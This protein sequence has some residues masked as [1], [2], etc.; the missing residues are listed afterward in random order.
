MSRNSL[1]KGTLI[2]TIAFIVAR[3][4]GV[5]QRVPLQHIMGNDGMN[6][7]SISFNLYNMLLTV[8]TL[9][10][11]TALAKQISEYTA[12]GK[13]SEAYQTYKASRNFAI[14]AGLVVTAFLY[15]FGPYYANSIAMAP[16]A[17][18][19]IQALAPAMM[20]FPLIAVMRG[21]FQGMQQ[22]MPTGISLIYEQIFRVSA[23]VILPL[24]LLGLNFSKEVAVAGASFGAVTG[25]IAAIAVMIYYYKKNRPIQVK[26]I[27]GQKSSSQLSVLTIYKKLFRLSIPITVASLTVTLLYFIDSSTGLR[28]LT[29]V[30]EQLFFN[31]NS[32]QASVAGKEMK[33]PVPVYSLGENTMVPLIPV[34]EALGGSVQWDES[35]QTA[36]YARNNQTI[37]LALNQDISVGNI[38]LKAPMEKKEQTLMVPASF[39]TYQLSGYRAAMEDMGILNGSAQSLAGLPI[40]L[41]VALSSSILPIVSAAYSRND[42]KEVQRMSSL[43]L[44][45]ALLTGV[46]AALFLTVGAL[47]VNGLLFKNSP[48]IIM[49]ASYII[50]FLCFGTIFQILMMIS[51][52]ILQGMGK[53]NHPMLFVLIGVIVKWIGNFVFTPFMGIYGIILSTSLCFLVIT[54][55]NIRAIN[56][57]TRLQVMGSKWKGL[58]GGSL[59][60]SLTGLGVVLLGMKV[61]P[62]V[63]IYDFLFYGL[64][65]I[66]LGVVSI[67]A[68]VLTLFWLKGMDANE[69]QYMPGIAKKAYNTLA[70]LHIVPRNVARELDVK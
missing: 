13:Y 21:Y 59:S 52:S 7:Y 40:I 24:V 9:G 58:I 68:Y 34:A 51:M 20:F 11:P 37:G 15:A 31:L 12:V 5:I 6:L 16:Q 29:P 44:R 18:L 2:L 42:E 4:L 36:I 55:L 33:L 26:Q 22:M 32:T 27:K 14:I 3:M 25:T 53:T 57:V 64:E 65:T 43:S 46:P 28:L 1:V 47:P 19:A 61:K 17:T 23:A 69:I 60:L 30:N 8:A 63:H 41:A 39:F 62:Y 45:L 48:D 56:K 35:T 49:R 70:R 50:S 10:I 67:T 38:N 66:V 54:L